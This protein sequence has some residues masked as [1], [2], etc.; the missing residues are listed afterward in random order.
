M[1]SEENDAGMTK[2]LARIS[3]L[4]QLFC[5]LLPFLVRAQ[6]LSAEN[7]ST[8]NVLDTVLV[9]VTRSRRIPIRMV[10]GPVAAA[11]APSS[12][13]LFSPGYGNGVDDYQAY[14]YLLN[15][16]A[17]RGYLVCAVQH[18][19][20]D[21]PVMPVSGDLKVVR[22]PF[23]ELG[24]ANLQ[25]VINYLHAEKSLKP[26]NNILL[27]GH[28]NGGDIS[29]L[30]SQKFPSQVSGV[31]SLDNRRM[32]LTRSREPWICS[33]R[34]SDQPADAGVLP[35][36]TEQQEFDITIIRLSDVRHNDMDRSATD[37]QHQS[38]LN[39]IDRCLAKHRVR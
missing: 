24:V 35:T 4:L 26:F 20:P 5:W 8:I 34:S 38:L 7:A 1:P 19:H 17:R 27:I 13:V 33:I 23:W 18:Q 25:Y 39:A 22:R 12:L 21:D 14:D 15:H 32:P 6:A 31:I 36:S 9:D 37:V 11:G 30:F 28:S 10:S 16:L 2:R 3:M 29:M